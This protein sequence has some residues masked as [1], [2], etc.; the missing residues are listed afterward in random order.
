[1]E[2]QVTLERQGH[3]F[4][5]AIGSCLSDRWPRS[6]VVTAATSVLAG[7]THSIL[8]NLTNKQLRPTAPPHPSMQ[9]QDALSFPT[10]SQA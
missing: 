9:R 6:V 7:G 2:G 8:C 1:M 3:D 4:T 5:S 10:A